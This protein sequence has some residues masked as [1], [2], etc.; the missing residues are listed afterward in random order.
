MASSSPPSES[1]PNPVR[2]E[3]KTREAERLAEALRENL[4][5]RK[6]Q[7][8]GRLQLDQEAK[9]QEVSLPKANRDEP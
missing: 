7:A 4:K 3:A 2:Q 9:L 6:Q 8:R 5:R 1:S